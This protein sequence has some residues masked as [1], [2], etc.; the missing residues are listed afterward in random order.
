MVN[1]RKPLLI[2][3][4]KQPEHDSIILINQNLKTQEQRFYGEEQKLFRKP[5]KIRYRT[6]F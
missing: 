1:C 5:Y 3:Q 4:I 6:V 2:E